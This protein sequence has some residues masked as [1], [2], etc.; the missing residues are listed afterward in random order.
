MSSTD[1]T[2]P[3]AFRFSVVLRKLVASG[4]ARGVIRLVERWLEHGTVSQTA[5]LAQARALLDLRLMDRAWVRLREAATA[6]PTSSEVQLLTARMFVERGWPAKASKILE[7][8]NLVE[9]PESEKEEFA[10]LSGLAEQPAKVPPS[11]ASEIERSG[12]ADGVL[13]LAESYM[14]VGMMV[15]AESLLERLLRDGF[16][17]PRV[18]DL[19]WALRGEFLSARTSTDALLDELDGDSTGIEWA[20]GEGTDSLAVPEITAHVDVAE[21]DASM[22][23]EVDKRGFPALF[24]RDDHSDET[25]GVDDEEVTMS[26]VLVESIAQTEASDFTDPEGTP[27]PGG[28][29]TRIME[30]IQRGDGVELGAAKGPIHKARGGGGSTV[31][32]LHSHREAFLPPDDETF[33]EDEDKDLIV[34]TRREGVAKTVQPKRQAAVEVLRQ[35]ASQPQSP[36]LRPRVE[37]SPRVVGAESSHNSTSDRSEL[38]VQDSSPDPDTDDMIHGLEPGN[39]RLHQALLGFGG[40]ALLTVVC[41]WLVVSVL[42]WIAE[43]QI[44]EEAHQTIASADF[45][46]LQ[47]LEA[48]LESQIEQERE[49]VA[50]RQVEL[51]LVQ[52]TLWYQYTGD[53]ERMLAAQDGLQ[54]ARESGA[55]PEEI[56]LLDVFL[57]LALGD[58]Q[59]A[60]MLIDSLAMDDPLQ[61]DLAAQVALRVRTDEESLAL[62][63][64]LGPVGPETPLIELLSRESLYTAIDNMEQAQVLRERLLAD[65]ANNPFV[66]ISRFHEQ[67]DED[68]PDVLLVLLADVMESLPGPVAPRQEGRLHAQRAL[69]LMEQGEREIAEQ[70]W[71]AALLLDPAHPR[72]LFHAASELL[73][74]NDIIG[75]LD[76]L[77]RCLGARPWDFSCR[78]GMI[79]ALIELDRLETARQSVEA[80]RDARTPILAAWVSLAEGKVDE[81]LIGLED[82]SGTLAAYIRGMALFES[83]S[84]QATAS[85]GTVIDV[86]SDI[87]D[88]MTQVLVGRAAVAKGLSEQ[89]VYEVE[90]IAVDFAPADPMAYVMLARVM[91]NAG[92]R[93]SAERLYQEA[94]ALG[95]QSALAHHALGLFWFEPQ[96]DFARA[97]ALWRKYLDLQPNGDRARRARARMG[98]R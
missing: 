97:R 34:M 30:V 85:L 62:L 18:S 2:G 76:D 83:G 86:W 91:E 94:V 66:Q 20:G 33:L 3:S 61:R 98:R 12:T 68:E 57:R 42:H 37:I 67:W 93:A 95:P 15:R 64:R 39:R 5:R 59:K 11:N 17:P 63:A 25:T 46:A 82:E 50:V 54:S 24:R 47:E 28:G 53:S 26:S 88:P 13:E 29:D 58:L 78:R 1:D 84:P 23:G 52:A 14:S 74:S 90:S 31:L 7:R 92:Q 49:P 73:S 89:R 72:Y 55:P 71:S 65:H 70:S 43:G 38:P 22:M 45:R 19:L 44:I 75:A 81:A 21:L 80:W 56:L 16:S 40:L 10:V 27:T 41:G 4:D 6:D 9:A 35:T 36:P 96:G 79:Q 32:D 51:A 8:L 60:R 77:D 69:L 87:D 48:K